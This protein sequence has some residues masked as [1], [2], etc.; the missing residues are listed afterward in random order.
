MAPDNPVVGSGPS[1]SPEE[2]AHRGF[3]STFR[4]FDP[5]EVRAFLERVSAEMRLLRDRFHEADRQRKD[6][7][8]RAAH[9]TLDESTLA[10]ALGEETARILRS[11]QEAAVDIR[12]KA[13]EN[14]ERIL[15]E[16]H[17][18][19]TRLKSE[20]EGM[21]AKRTAEADAAATSIREAAESWAEQVRARAAEEAE[22]VLAAARDEGRGILEEAQNLRG[23]VLG[24][25]ARR[26]KVGHAQVEQLRAGRERLLDAYRVVRRTLD[27]V[28]E[29]LQRAEVE[30]RAAAETAAARMAVE[31]EA[32]LEEME[33]AILAVRDT[34]PPTPDPPSVTPT[35][36]GDTVR[37]VASDPTPPSPGPSAS[38]TTPATTAADAAPA[39]A[40]TSPPSPASPADKPDGPSIAAPV[41]SAKP[42]ITSV[43]TTPPRSGLRPPPSTSGATPPADPADDRKL[44]SLRILRRGR[45]DDAKAAPPAAGRASEGEGVR[46]IRSGG[47]P[48]V[49]ETE[50]EAAA[51]EAA[52][53][54]D[55]ADA[56]PTAHDPS[57]MAEPA[58]TPS[59][60]P[61]AAEPAGDE[62]GAND[63]DELFARL[64]AG[65]EVAADEA[66]QVLSDEGAPGDVEPSRDPAVEP[67]AGG[68]PAEPPAPSEPAEGQPVS[69]DAEADEPGSSA[70]DPVADA[71]EALL[72]RRDEALDPVERQLARRIK[73]A[74][75]DDQNDLLDRLRQRG[76]AQAATVLGDADAHVRRLAEAS[77]DHLTEAAKLGAEAGG[78]ANQPPAIDDIAVELG[79]ALGS[80]LRAK[81]EAAL[82]GIDSEGDDE[83]AAADRV[84]VAYRE[85]KSARIERLAGDHLVAAYSRGVLAAAPAGTAFRWVVSDLDG[86]CPDCDDNSL[87]GP[88][89]A[90]EAYPTGQP[91]PPAHAGC[92]CLLAPSPS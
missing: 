46:I 27:E 8:N 65:R 69:A 61:S 19:A 33:S 5:A 71:D 56:G 16:A 38:D 78:G 92:R 18:E 89:A 13:E 79:S 60:A 22:Q 70:A 34:Q 91:Q 35:P 63:V 7:E 55:A 1:L 29:E 68:G 14:V 10:S 43:T 53:A 51:A 80:V 86:P 30:A 90:G 44:S 17:A 4:G 52:E 58:A 37:L 84:G 73:R 76:R 59:S 45:G 31:P 26:R 32:T 40:S 47:V 20:S 57:P 15:A 36:A 24:D 82:A 41:A 6:A 3:A 62:A 81:L 48:P 83:P 28:T 72:Q 23:K 66:R 25:L 50:K 77:R 9:P 49:G 88:T 64:R 12:A 67:A 74:L 54:A 85:W 75:Q 42:G 87:A 11:A 39:A 21:L 2:V